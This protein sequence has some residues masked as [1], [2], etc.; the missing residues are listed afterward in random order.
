MR[1]TRY[2]EDGQRLLYDHFKGT[3]VGHSRSHRSRHRQVSFW[4]HLHQDGN[5]TPAQV[6]PQYPTEKALLADQH[7]FATEFGFTG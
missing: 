4:Q 3:Q 6:G 5:E 1:K 2:E 7:R